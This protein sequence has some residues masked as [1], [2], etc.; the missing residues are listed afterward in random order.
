[1]LI[2][3]SHPYVIV[4]TWTEDAIITIISEVMYYIIVK[5]W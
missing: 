3:D 5:A 1:M 4:I 2:G